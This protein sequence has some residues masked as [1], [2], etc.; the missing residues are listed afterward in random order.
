MGNDFGSWI[1][2]MVPRKSDKRRYRPQ[3]DSGHSKQLRRDPTSLPPPQ[4]PGRKGDGRGGFFF[5]L[6]D[7]ARLISGFP[8][9]PDRKKDQMT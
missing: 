5:L 1:G 8:G 2:E 7:F 6:S 3:I 4:F 9:R